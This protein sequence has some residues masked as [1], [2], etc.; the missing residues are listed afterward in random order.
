MATLVLWLPLPAGADAPVLGGALP[1]PLPL[2]P[3]TNWWNIDISSA[4]VDSG[5]AAF[6]SFINNGSPRKLHPDFSADLSPGGTEIGGFPYIVVDSAQPKKTVT[7]LYSDESDGVDR[8]T[9]KGIPFYPI[10]DEAITQTRWVEGGRPGNVDLRGSQDRHMLIVDRD[11]RFLYELY[12]VY[13]DGKSWLAGSG[14]F[15]DLNANR[16]RADGWTSADAAGLAILPGLVRYDEVFGSDEIKHAFRMTVRATNGYVYPASHRAGSNSQALPMGA[17]LRLKAGRDISSFRP[18]IQKVFRAMKRYGLMVADNGSDMYIS[19]AYDS[20]WNND[21]LNPAFAA[22]TAN[23]FEVIQ[24]AYDPVRVSYFPHLA[25]GGGFSTVFT[26]ANTSGLTL[27][28]SLSFTD[29]VG[30]PFL[31]AEVDN[32][33]A[34]RPALSESQMEK[35]GFIPF[36]LSAGATRIL[37][38]ALQS[39]TEPTKSGWAMLES[40]GGDLSGVATFKLVQNGSIQ[41]IAGVFA[42]QLTGFAT[43]PV[44]NNDELRRYTGFAL[45]N[46]GVEDVVIQL[47]TISED[48]EARDSIRP[49]DL[50]PPGANKQV[51]K[52]LHELLPERLRFRGSLVLTAQ[53]GRKFAVVALIQ[54]QGLY[55]A[56][57]VL[58]AKAPNVPN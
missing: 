17:R 33:P 4:P 45:A 54:N 29:Q 55:S 39:S 28:G 22:L 26:L 35:P 48:G 24:L 20:R 27:T 38:L 14:A 6:I 25:V 3:P 37:N 40:I 8:A 7:F 21:I 42:S 9:G 23:D 13:Y 31:P 57:P 58:P 46:P 49:G 50:T 12:N 36:S 44:D 41:T 16:R 5:S 52:F 34:A 2:F 1:Q 30:N 18:E 32:A 56:V 15:F 53:G 11:N 47:V 19:G 10:P 43:I 51:A